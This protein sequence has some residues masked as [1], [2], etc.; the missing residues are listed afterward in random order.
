MTDFAAAPGP[1]EAPPGIRV[2]AQFV[3]D[4]SF[5]NPR[6]PDSLRSQAGPPQI[7]LGVEV[8]ARGR[9]DQL[10]EAD[11]KLNVTAQSGGETLFHIELLYG[12]LFQLN[13]IAPEDMEPV[14]LIECPRYLFPY[15]RRLIG[16]LTGEGGFPP[17]L[18]DPIDFGA[19]Y[20]SRLAQAQGAPLAQV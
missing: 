9:P 3:R 15:V 8:N 4:L 1:A 20:Q 19:V 18:L 11:L 10:F 7:E 14:L 16:D 13:G 2:V 12:G 5:E 17:L 6:A